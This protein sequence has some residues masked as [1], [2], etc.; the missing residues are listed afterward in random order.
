MRNTYAQ[1][2]VKKYNSKGLLIDSNL[3]LLLII[4]SVD[5]SLIHKFKRTD[6]FTVED[7]QI[8]SKLSKKFRK[9]VTTSH[10][11]T[12]VSNFIGKLESNFKALSY[13]E[14]LKH[15]ELLDEQNI[16]SRQLIKTEIFYKWFGLTDSSIFKVAQSNFLVLTT[17][18][19]LY[20]FLSK[21]GIDAINFN[22]LR[23]F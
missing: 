18:L 6:Q 19:P 13:M 8:L 4:G 10:I 15:I 12:E 20:N 11:L 5:K 17:D 7:Y 23:K 22:H 9:I 3:L 14:L 16:E 1:E 2:M 21:K